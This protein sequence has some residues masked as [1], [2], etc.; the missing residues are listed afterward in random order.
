MQNDALRQRL[1]EK[2][3]GNLSR[4]EKTTLNGQVRDAFNGFFHQLTGNSHIGRAMLRH[5]FNSAAALHN[6]LQ[7]YYEYM[8]SDEYDEIKRKQ[9]Q[10]EANRKALR[11]RALAARA[12]VKNAERLSRYIVQYMSNHKRPPLLSTSDNK[13]VE[14]LS[15]GEL[16]RLRLTANQR[17][18]HGAGA[19]VEYLSIERMTTIRATTL[20]VAAHVQQRQ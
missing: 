1:V 17:Y 4:Q 8:N 3:L 19:D 6:L 11:A 2:E 10:K 20:G 16:H 5:G 7:A 12:Q 14:R 13:L 9:M 18:G 15:S